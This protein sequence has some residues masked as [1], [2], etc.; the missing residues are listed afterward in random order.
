MKDSL[1]TIIFATVL[2]VVCAGL[3]AAANQVLK[4]YYE[5]NKEADKL[6]N[7]F[8]VLGVPYSKSATSEELLQ[9][10]R[11][12]NPKGVVEE[13]KVAGMTIYTYDNPQAGKLYA[14]EF[15]GPGLWGPVKGLLCLKSDMKTVYS[16]AF[17]EQEETPGLGAEISGP[18]FC[19]QFKDK[20]IAGAGE[21][22]IRV[23]KPAQAKGNSEV[24]GISGATLTC[25]KVSAMINS[26]S[27]K[28]LDNRQA[29]EK[30]AAKSVEARKESGNE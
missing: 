17:Y 18:E 5:A 20:T 10:T 9:L 12:K 24:D 27:R 15:D 2:G 21:P 19:G 13:A 8:N 14:V 28:V 23:A 7:V 25:D 26:I 4:P 11:A 22:G 30:A 16:I 1:K 6:K 3:L 29:I